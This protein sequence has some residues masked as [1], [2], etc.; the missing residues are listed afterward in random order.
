MIFRIFARK[1]LRLRILR[2][3]LPGWFRLW[4]VIRIPPVR[5]PKMAVVELWCWAFLLNIRTRRRL[6][7]L[8]WRKVRL[9][10]QMYLW[11]LMMISWMPRLMAVPI[12]NNIQLIRILPFMW[13]ISMLLAYGKKLFI[14]LG[15]PLNRVCYSGTRSYVSLYQTAMRIWGSVRFPRILVARYL[16]VRMIVAVC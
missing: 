9:Q 11:R 12:S 7:T 13:R 2:W 3:L 15:N 8:R 5:W 14:T 16:F 6:S 1:V 4:N 10:V